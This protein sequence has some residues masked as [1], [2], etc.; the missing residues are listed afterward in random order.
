MQAI[1]KPVC[2]SWLF[3]LERYRGDLSSHVANLRYL[4]NRPGS[5]Y[6]RLSW[7]SSPANAALSIH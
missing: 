5:T 6:N 4:T 1:I 7:S 3:V 2:V